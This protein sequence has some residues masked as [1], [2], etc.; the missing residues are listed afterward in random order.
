MFLSV[1]AGLVLVLVALAALVLLARWFF[2]LPSLQ[3]RQES[4]SIPMGRDTELDRAVAALMERQPEGTSGILPLTQGAEAFAV[5]VLLARAA[6][7]SIDARYYIWQRDNTGLPLLDELRAAAARGV[8]IR[9]LVDDNGTAG[10]D[11]EL[12]MLNALPNFEVRIFNP[13]TLRKPRLASYL[14]DFP[15]LNRRMHNKSFCVDGAV[16]ILGGRNIGDIYFARD[17][18][19]QY[20][21]IDLLAAGP[22]VSDVAGNFD[23]YWNSDSAHPHQKIVRHRPGLEPAFT[24]EVEAARQGDDA[25]AYAAALR[26]TKVVSDLAAKKLALEWVHVTMH[27]DPP[28]KG[29]NRLAPDRLLAADLSRI[30]GGA[31]TSLE[32]AS[33]YFVPGSRGSDLLVN[34]AK[35]G[36]SVAVL[37]NSLEATDVLPVHASYAKYRRRLLEGGVKLY[38]FKASQ[39]ETEKS[40]M[41]MLGQSAASLHA[42]IF[43]IDRSAVF[44]GSFNFDPRSINLNCEMGYLAQSPVLVRHMV[45]AFDRELSQASWAVSLK[46]D[47]TL[48]WSGTDDGGNLIQRDDEPG[49]TMVDRATIAALSVLPV[50]WMM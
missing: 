46:K 9:L 7:R 39:T 35:S 28:E 49:S 29:L 34:L 45:E 14:F 8:R 5:R 11:D 1:F 41:G 4:H 36:A 2:P 32:I 21:D 30:A 15:R 22:V 20:F 26:G 16:A 50:E 6:T 24:A 31:T 13:F 19:V 23:A 3:G 12:A 40:L 18:K 25:Q 33:A 43:L 17:S 48:A 47:G 37:T 38:E 10:L 42:K 27:S 44:V